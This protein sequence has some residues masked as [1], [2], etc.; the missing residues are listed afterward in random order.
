MLI[1]DV[2]S[3]MMISIINF[4]DILIFLLRIANESSI[5]VYSRVPIQS[6]LESNCLKEKYVFRD[7]KVIEAFRLMS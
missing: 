7:Q 2:E 5:Q 6:F 1:E 3:K 4:K